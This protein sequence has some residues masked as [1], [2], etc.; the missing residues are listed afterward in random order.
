[1]I[2]E[3][4]LSRSHNRPHLSCTIEYSRFCT[5]CIEFFYQW[6]RKNPSFQTDA[7]PAATTKLLEAD[8]FPAASAKLLEADAF[9][10]ATAK[11]LEVDAFPAASAKL[12]E[13]DAVPACNPLS[14]TFKTTGAF[15]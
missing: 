3:A 2:S 9:P 10:A 15:L 12:L 8:A 6:K 4:Y 1:L 11:L 7:V 13:A 5:I 14:N